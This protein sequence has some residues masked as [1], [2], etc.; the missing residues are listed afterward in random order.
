MF[1]RASGAQTHIITSDTTMVEKAD[2]TAS[3]DEFEINVLRKV[4]RKSDATRVA[5]A[6]HWL[7]RQHWT[8]RKGARHRLETTFIIQI[9]AF[10]MQNAV[11]CHV[12]LA[13]L[14]HSRTR[15][16]HLLVG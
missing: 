6:I 14:Y 10:L 5:V 2:T 8:C 11:E 12:E 1:I 9:A 4:L 15:I 7:E 16:T 13:R 3:W